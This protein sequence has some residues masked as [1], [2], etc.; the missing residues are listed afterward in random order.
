MV[1]AEELLG[2]PVRRVAG[3]RRVRHPVDL[4]GVRQAITR[5]A[6]NRRVLDEPLR[7]SIGV[8]AVALDAQRQR[9][10]SLWR[11][12]RRR[13]GGDQTWIS[14]KEPNGFWQALQVCQRITRRSGTNPMSRR[15]SMRVRAM[16]A[17]LPSIS[18]RLA[19]W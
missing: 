5:C 3:Q 13:G 19:P 2:A 10:K 14:R 6:A 9:L 17:A 15:P 12:V 7:Q 1:R 8:L 16:N 4:C 11:L 18:A